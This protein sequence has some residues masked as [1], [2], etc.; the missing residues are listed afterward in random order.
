MMHKNPSRNRLLPHLLTV[1]LLGSFLTPIAFTKAVAA[2]GDKA[3]SSSNAA[4][5]SLVQIKGLQGLGTDNPG[6]GLGPRNDPPAASPGF[7]G[8]TFPSIPGVHQ[9]FDRNFSQISGLNKGLQPGSPQLKA[10]DYL[11]KRPLSFIENR[12]QTHTSVRYE[13]RAAT[14]TVFFTPQ[15]A[16]FA[17]FPENNDKRM[18]EALRVK[19]AGAS[20]NPTVSGLDRLSANYNFFFGNDPANWKADVPTYSSIAY[21]GLYKGV[22]LIYRDSKG[23]IERDF[24]IAP[25]TTPSVI[26]M[27]YEGAKKV[28]VGREGNL[29]VETD[30]SVLSESK[31]FAYQEIKG[32]RVEVAASFKLARDGSV[33]FEVGRYDATEPLVIDPVFGF[34]TYVG[35]IGDDQAFGLAVDTT[36]VYVTGVT[37][38]VN[39]PV[40]NTFG[41]R[42]NADTFAFKLSP[43][44][45]TLIYSAI[46][47][48]TG[49]DFGIAT[50]V[51]PT[52]R[53]LY[54]LG[55][56]DS[57]NFPTTVGAFDT[58]FNGGLG[59]Y[60]VTRLNAAGMGWSGA[61]TLAVREKS[62]V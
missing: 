18:G 11:A 50:Q 54:V 27:K 12:D 33:G 37:T 48:G 29:V 36:G 39:F 42:A 34:S 43:D 1:V 57:T 16:V 8:N 31:P 44:G 53:T 26:K 51:H 22:D 32:E 19:F 14:H 10:T 45:S 30:L 62:L 49:T 15:E 17:T 23:K 58:T 4:L 38:S 13:V 24:V 5:S 55:F 35:G 46:L 9:V 20:P 60:T 7:K 28:R 6:E 3:V 40:T 21:T 61:L 56:T 25:G 41:T 2:N 47:A 52:D 59:D